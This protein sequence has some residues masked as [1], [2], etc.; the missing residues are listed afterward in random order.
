MLNRVLLMGHLGADPELRK[1]AAGAEQVKL[2][3]ATPAGKD[4]TDWHNL[5]CFGRVAEVAM[6]YTQKGALCLITG[7]IHYW[8]HQ[9][10]EGPK[11]LRT[12]IVVDTLQV[13]SGGKKAAAAP[14]L[15]PPEDDDIPF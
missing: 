11:R 4:K 13:V 5:V 14:R 9:P 15:E 2:R 1:T 3:M 7:K 12:D 10:K 8:D 6:N